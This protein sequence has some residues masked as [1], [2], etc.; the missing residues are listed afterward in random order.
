MKIE[1]DQR[2]RGRDTAAGIELDV[3]AAAAA[4]V[5]DGPET[6]VDQKV[7]DRI[8]V[9]DQDLADNAAGRGVVKVGQTAVGVGSAA[10]V[11]AAVAASG[12]GVLAVADAA[13]IAAV[14]ADAADDGL[15]GTPCRRRAMNQSRCLR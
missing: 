6:A 9:S 1:A 14:A 3:P 2:H 10:D 5:A 7:V 12:A 11:A 13:G 8:G 15:V 4:A